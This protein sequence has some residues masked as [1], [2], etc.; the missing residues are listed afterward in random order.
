M[1]VDIV[2]LN[3]KNGKGDSFHS[4]WWYWRPIWAFTV[5][6][7]GRIMDK[8]LTLKTENEEIKYK[9]WQAGHTN[10]G[11]IVPKEM[12]EQIGKRILKVL[13]PTKDEAERVAAGLKGGAFETI[14]KA[15]VEVEPKHY[16]LDKD[17]LKEWAE[18]CLNCGGF[19][20]Y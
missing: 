20:V 9:A 16:H 15:I 19:A 10:D 13:E 3:P 14:K 6:V 12:A 7:C 4:N 2:G 8:E 18:F 17:L 5:I 11:F 1:V